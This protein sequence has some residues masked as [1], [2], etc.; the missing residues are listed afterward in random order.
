[1]SNNLNGT[2]DGGAGNVY[3]LVIDQHSE[4]NGT[5][6]GY[7]HD[8]RTNKWEKITGSFSF[9]RDGRDETV[10]WFSTPESSWRW[11]ADFTYGAPSFDKWMTKRTSKTNAND[12]ETTDFYKESTTPLT[13]TLAELK[14]GQ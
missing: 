13:P 11:E 9:Y 7:F 6:S 14:Y 8:I 3:R 10:L 12:I 2:F 4:P 5:F 1:M